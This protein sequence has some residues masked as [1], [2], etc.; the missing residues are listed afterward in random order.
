MASWGELASAEPELAAAG[1]SLLRAFT[2]GYL[3]TLRADG[4]PRVHPVT[5]TLHDGGLYVFPI[6]GSAKAADLA[7]DP[8]YALHSFPRAWSDEAWDDEELEADG[9]RMSFLD[10]LDELRRRIVYSLIGIG[11][12]LGIAL[13]FIN[14][15]FMF[16]FQP[17]QRMLPAGQTRSV[18]VLSL[19]PR[20]EQTGM[21]P[22]RL[23]A[24]EPLLE[25]GLALSLAFVDALGAT[26]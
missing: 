15:L 26:P 7:R 17:M 20:L 1:E 12:G 8:R 3:A 11:V 18:V 4:S 6:G 19:Y 24:A 21:I 14:D 10:H 2:I 16:I 23:I 9:A 13:F 5:V 25:H 22:R